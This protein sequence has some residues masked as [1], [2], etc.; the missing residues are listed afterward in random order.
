LGLNLQ[1]GILAE[2]TE[3]GKPEGV[4]QFRDQFAKINAFL[5]TKGIRP[6][7]EPEQSGHLTS[8]SIDMFGYGGL[9]ELRRVALHLL[10][11]NGVP[12][13]SAGRASNDPLATEAMRSPSHPTPWAFSHLLVHS[14]CSGY[15]LPTNFRFVLLPT[16]NSGIEG[17]WIGSSQRLFEECRALAAAVQLPEGLDPESDAFDDV[18]DGTTEQVADPPPWRRLPVAPHACAVLLKG[19]SLSIESKAALVFG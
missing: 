15:Y 1:V 8:W 12:A 18:L 14:D 9:H 11:G 4:A 2:L 10:A 7:H 6:H 5:A 16:A 13:A 3:V 17:P 19:A